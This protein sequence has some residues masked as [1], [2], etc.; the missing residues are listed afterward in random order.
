MPSAPLPV[1][2]VP[3]IYLISRA[4]RLPVPAYAHARRCP[5]LTY[6]PRASSY[7]VG[8]ST[9]VRPRTSS[10]AVAPPRKKGEI[11]R[12]LET[13]TAHLSW[14][15]PAK[16]SSG[17]LLV[18]AYAVSGTD[19]AVWCS[20]ALCD[21]QYCPRGH[22][23]CLCCISTGYATS[24]MNLVYGVTTV[25]T[26]L[27]YGAIARYAMSGTELAYGASLMF[28][29]PLSKVPSFG[30]QD[31]VPPG[32]TWP[33][34]P[35]DQPQAEIQYKKPPFQHTCTRNAVSCL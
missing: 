27:A 5:V 20:D 21:G 33:P 2:L 29:P 15:S 26:D 34:L 25:G 6:G 11:R 23:V 3:R 30:K 16:G 14:P 8:T 12:P 31:N 35:T 32:Q 28:E 24:D 22:A 9:F 19:L 10:G 17:Q 7:G 4:A 13:V 18:P 1:Q